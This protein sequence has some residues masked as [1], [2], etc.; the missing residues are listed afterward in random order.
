MIVNKTLEAAVDSVIGLENRF[1]RDLMRE[2]DHISNVIEL[3]C[4][5]LSSDESR[6][7]L[8]TMFPL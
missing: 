2:N 5:E 1:L 6:V 4:E 8:T 7:R 3:F